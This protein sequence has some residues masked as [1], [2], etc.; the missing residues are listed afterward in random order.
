V[1]LLN[2]ELLSTKL[3]AKLIDPLNDLNNEDFSIK[4]DAGPNEAVRPL[5][6]PLA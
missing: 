2:S 6:R 4:L 3:V 1:K 5:A